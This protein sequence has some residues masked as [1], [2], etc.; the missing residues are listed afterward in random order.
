MVL[1]TSSGQAQFKSTVPLV[2]APTIVTDSKGRYVDGLTP[3][4]LT[5]Y[6]NGVPQAIQMDWMKYPIDL[7][8]AVE[9]CSNSGAVIDKLSG[10]GILFTQLLAADAGETAVIS[11]SDQVKVH[12][13]FTSNPDSV[14]HALRILR[15]EGGEAHSLDALHHALLMLEHRPP[16]R[17]PIILMIAEKRDRSSK[18]K[19]GDVMERV[20]R[21]NAA[22]YWLTYSPFLEPFTVKPK[23][24]EDLKPEAERIKIQKCA[25]CPAPDDTPVPPDLGPGDP[26]YG[27]RELMRLRQP[28]LSSLLPKT[29]GGRTRNFLKKNALEQAIQLVSEEVHRQYILSFEPKSGEPGTFHTIRVEVK[30]RP[31][32]QAKT[33]E[34]YWRLE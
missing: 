17:R 1:L 18:A 29:T 24:S 5:L 6:D 7:V 28:D 23:T 20:Q 8:V 32:L 25:V 19:L 4:D 26:I 21:L 30:D 13:D 12:Q 16:G 34:G 27:I 31:D 14:I 9:T 2:V 22:I 11:F 3:E 15:K 33:R 10:S